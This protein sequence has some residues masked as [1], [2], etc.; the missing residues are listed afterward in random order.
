MGWIPLN[1]S[2]VG[3]FVGLGWGCG[4]VGWVGLV[5]VGNRHCIMNNLV[6]IKHNMLTSSCLFYQSV[7]VKEE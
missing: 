4:E 6:L 7:P 3:W 1:C 5:W 2:L